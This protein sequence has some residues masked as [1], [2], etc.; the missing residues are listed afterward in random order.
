LVFL[1]KLT[2]IKSSVMF[3]QNVHV[4]PKKCKLFKHKVDSTVHEHKPRRSRYIPVTK[5]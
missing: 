2:D 1:Y 3:N 4:S 5:A